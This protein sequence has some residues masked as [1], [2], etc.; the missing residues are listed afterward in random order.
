MQDL[1]KIYLEGIAFYFQKKFEKALESFDKI[2]TIGVNNQFYFYCKARTLMKLHKFEEAL[3]I[4][5]MSLQNLQ[6]YNT[7]IVLYIY[8]DKGVVLVKLKRL[9]QALECFNKGIAIEPTCFFFYFN[10][11]NLLYDLQNYTSSIKCFEKCIR[12]YPLSSKAYYN[13]GHLRRQLKI[14]KKALCCYKKCITQYKKVK[15]LDKL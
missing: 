12:L 4:L 2:C 10:K 11:G 7:K 1:K 3:V 15:F 14:Y 8:N 5:D 13:E 9:D 6:N